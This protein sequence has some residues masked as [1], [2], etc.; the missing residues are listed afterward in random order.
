MPKSVWSTETQSVITQARWPRTLTVNAGG[1]EVEIDTPFPS[2][3]DWRDQWIYQILVDRFNN[4]QAP[5]RSQWDRPVNAFQ[6]GTFNG[7][8]QQLDYLR[9]LGVGA[10]WLTPVLKNCQCPLCLCG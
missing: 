10:L 8:R 1:T 3:E 4:D 6:G 9:D 7:I 5:P 2:P